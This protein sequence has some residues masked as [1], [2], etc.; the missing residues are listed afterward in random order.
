MITPAANDAP[1]AGVEPPLQFPTNGAPVGDQPQPPPEDADPE[2]APPPPPS[3]EVLACVAAAASTITGCDDNE[4]KNYIATAD[5]VARTIVLHL[6]ENWKKIRRVAK[7]RV[8]DSKSP[9]VAL[10]AAIK[11]NHE[12]L[13]LMDTRVKTSFA[14]KYEESS[15]TQQ[16]LRQVTLSLPTET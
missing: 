3:G 2:M 15:E 10:S 14:Q 7:I 5:Y 4:L 11:I 8:D 13:L 9:V 12:N 16:D 1:E 6:A